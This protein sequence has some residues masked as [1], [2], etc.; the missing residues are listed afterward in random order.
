MAARH[1]EPVRQQ[2]QRDGGQQ[3][4]QEKLFL[5]FVFFFMLLDLNLFLGNLVNLSFLLEI[6]IVFT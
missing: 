6:I 1:A 3:W 2:L 4:I 5:L